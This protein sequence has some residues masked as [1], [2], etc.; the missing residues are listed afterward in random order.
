MHGSG[1]EFAPAT[2]GDEAAYV[3]LY[4]ALLAYAQSAS[5]GSGGYAQDP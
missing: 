4:N 3:A 5:P 1:M 2:D